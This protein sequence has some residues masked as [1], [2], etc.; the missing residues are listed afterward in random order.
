LAQHRCWPED[1]HVRATVLVYAGLLAHY[2]TDMVQ[3]LHTSEHY[4][5]RALPG[6]ES[7]RSGIHD[8]VDSLFSQP[9]FEPPPPPVEVAAIEDIWRGVEDEFFA[10]HALVDRVYE[11]EAELYALYSGGAWGRELQAFAVDRYGRAVSVLAGL[12]LGA[13][14]RSAALELSPWLVRR[15]ADGAFH[16]CP[17]G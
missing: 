13:W 5:G 17:A 2:A 4:D 7:P 16:P 12:Y 8:K 1:P 9:G 6:G 15:G 11:L 14:R 10:S 3:P